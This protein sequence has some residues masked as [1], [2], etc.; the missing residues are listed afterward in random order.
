MNSFLKTNKSL[1]TVSLISFLIIPIFGFNFLISILSNI[2]LLFILI[3]IAAI[4][5]L[6]IS[7]NSFKSNLKTCSQCGAISIGKSSNC[8][9]CGAD[10][11]RNNAEDNK[12][13]N[14]PGE[15]TIEIKAEEVK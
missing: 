12:L 8:M 9:N 10:L 13:I 3:P 1:V 11:N 14:N 2:L 5:I 6:L 15:R 7:F 4:I